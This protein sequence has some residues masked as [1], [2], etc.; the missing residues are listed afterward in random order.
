MFRHTLK[1]ALHLGLSLFLFQVLLAC[2]T[3]T[4]SAMRQEG[5]PCPPPPGPPPGPPPTPPTDPLPDPR[6]GIKILKGNNSE[7]IFLK[8]VFLAP[9]GTQKAF[10]ENTWRKGDSSHIQL[11]E[12]AE[13][14]VLTAKSVGGGQ[15]RVCATILGTNVGYIEFTDVPVSKVISSGEK[16]DPKC[17]E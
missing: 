2:S 17:Q 7:A 8:A 6:W 4:I 1:S 13:A 11:N 5:P 15:G 9:D 12:F 16:Q 3:D 14:I 10:Y